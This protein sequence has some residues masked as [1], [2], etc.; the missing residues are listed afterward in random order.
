MAKSVKP[1]VAKAPKEKP[2]L[3]KVE[4][5]IEPVI[6]TPIE[7]SIVGDEPPSVTLDEVKRVEE[8]IEPI[9]E[10]PK[11]IVE[12]VEEIKPTIQKEDTYAYAATE[13]KD[14]SMEEKVLKFIES[15]DG[16]IKMNDFLKSLFGVPKFGEPAVWLS[17]A[18][19]KELR[20]VLAK[21]NNEGRINIISNAHMNLGTFYYPDTTTG[22]TA[23][24]N[25]NT[26]SIIAKK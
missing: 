10:E 15:R 13:T 21:L 4:L 17:Q 16:E 24:H 9:K 3:P 12:V 8:V 26:V 1:K 23:Y 18:T 5:P 25:L 20:G 22:K 14:L 19:S 2:E 6:E 11:V 7:E